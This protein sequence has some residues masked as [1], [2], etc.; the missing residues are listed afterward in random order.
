MRILLDTDAYSGLMRG[1]ETVAARARRAEGILLSSVVVGEL[2]YG[3]RNGNRYEENRSQLEAFLAN[4]FVQFLPVTFATADRFG[5]IGAALRRKGTPIPSNDIWIAAH[6]LETGA[7]LISIDD[8][9]R[10]VDGLSFVHLRESDIP[11][12][13]S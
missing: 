5:L 2:L 9:F 12:D 1:S 6:A 4:R 3:F 8:H 7:D 10:H 13:A 11:P